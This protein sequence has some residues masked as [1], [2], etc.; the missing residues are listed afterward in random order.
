M[1]TSN[2]GAFNSCLLSVWQTESNRRSKTQ[3]SRV[4]ASNRKSKETFTTSVKSLS[5]PRRPHIFPASRTKDLWGPPPPGHKTAAAHY[6]YYLFLRCSYRCFPAVNEWPPRWVNSLCMYPYLMRMLH[7]VGQ[8][9]I[10]SQVIMAEKRSHR[11]SERA[12]G[13]S[14]GAFCFSLRPIVANADSVFSPA[15]KLDN[16]CLKRCVGARW[17]AIKKKK[18]SAPHRQIKKRNSFCHLSSCKSET[19]A[20]LW[21]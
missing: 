3:D 8:E 14:R 16:T 6:C 4:H 5:L 19:I 13:R 7:K 21:S 20:P 15:L 18:W 11:N 9:L 2:T 10:N 1:L 12:R 17:V